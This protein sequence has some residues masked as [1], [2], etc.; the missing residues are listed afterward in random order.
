MNEFSEGRM[1]AEGSDQLCQFDYNL[2]ILGFGR[3]ILSVVLGQIQTSLY[4]GQNRLF[5]RHLFKAPIA[6][7]IS[8][9][10][11]YFE[12]DFS[13]LIEIMILKEKQI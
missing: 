7:N 12:H 3:E 6:E 9:E 4:I 8:G 11:K 10:V 13:I 5:L 1:V 2:V